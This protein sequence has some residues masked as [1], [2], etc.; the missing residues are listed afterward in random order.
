MT[1]NGTLS[2]DGT[3][4]TFSGIMNFK[5]YCDSYDTGGATWSG[6]MNVSG[7]MASSGSSMNMLMEMDLFTISEPSGTSYS[8]RGNVYGNITYSSISL[9]MNYFMRDDTSGKVYKL[10]DYSMTLTV[11]S[12]DTDY[13]TFSGR[14]YD[15]NYGYVVLSTSS[16]LVVYSGNAYPSSGELIIEG[17]EGTGI[18]LIFLDA[19]SFQVDVETSGDGLYDDFTSGTQLW[20]NV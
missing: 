11:I 5:A 2:D 1:L 10:E 13:L 4:I 12:M 20:S 16:S 8:F 17:A 3:T 6:N 18:R 9:T 15:P 7:S 14:Y 19:S